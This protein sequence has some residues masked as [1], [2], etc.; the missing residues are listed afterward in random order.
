MGTWSFAVVA[1]GGGDMVLRSV[2]DL[3]ATLA[4]YRGKTMLVK[5][6][7]SKLCDC[8]PAVLSMGMTCITAWNHSVLKK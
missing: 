2:D 4:S 5:A 7:V 3:A 1:L 8:R 6:A